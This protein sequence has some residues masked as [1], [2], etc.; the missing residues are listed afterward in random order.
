MRDNFPAD[1]AIRCSLETGASLHWLVTGEGATFDHLASDTVRIPA[2]KIEGAKLLKTTSIIF[3]KVLL[4]DHKGDLEIISV[5]RTRYL[6]D[7][8]SYSPGDGNF[9]IEYS[10][11]Q[12]IKELTL[13]P[14]NKLRIDWGKYPLDCDVSDL[15]IIGKVLMTLVV[16][17]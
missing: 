17:N 9:F 13:L 8:A 5:G 1:I 14:G 10:D 12:S 3:D 4:P 11:T 6:V 16:N 15:K 2:Y 7:K